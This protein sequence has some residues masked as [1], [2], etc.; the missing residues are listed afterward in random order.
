VLGGAQAPRAKVRAQQ[1]ATPSF[2]KHS[3]TL[4]KTATSVI[5]TLM[6]ITSSAKKALRQNVTRNKRN[7]IKKVAYKKAVT[8]F[9]KLV[10]AKKLDEAAKALPAAFKALDKAAKTKVI[11]KNK[12]SRLK[13]RL[14]AQLTSKSTKAS[15]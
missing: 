3:G 1:R 5:M 6:P 2:P 9:R 15:S 4:A 7:V 8:D 11:E 12:A 13:S 10:V 14:S